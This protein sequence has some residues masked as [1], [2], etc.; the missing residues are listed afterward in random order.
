MDLNPAT[1]KG[2]THLKRIESPV[3]SSGKTNQ[4]VSTLCWLWGAGIS[5]SFP[6]TPG[7]NPIFF[8]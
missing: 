3:D 6:G 4:P 7:K 1:N 5:A 2:T 8:P